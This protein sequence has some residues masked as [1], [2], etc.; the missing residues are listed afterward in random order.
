MSLQSEWIKVSG[1]IPFCPLEVWK[2]SLSRVATKL[3]N[4][5]K[6]GNLKIMKISGKGEG[7]L[8]LCRKTWKLREKNKSI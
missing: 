2:E 8:N 1:I 4:M 7:N 5:E 6:S 3:E